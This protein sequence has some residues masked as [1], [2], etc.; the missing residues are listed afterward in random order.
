MA[1]QESLTKKYR[2]DAA[3]QQVRLSWVQLTEQ[4]A[5][6]IRSAGDFLRDD[7]ADD[8]AR[9]LRALLQVSGIRRQGGGGRFEPAD[10]GG[11]P[12]G[13]LLLHP[14]RQDRRRVLRAPAAYRGDPRAAR[15][16]ASLEPGQL[17][18]VR[19]P[20]HP[21]A[22]GAPEGADAAQHDQGV[23]EGLL[24]RW[25]A[26]GGGLHHRRR[27]RPAGAGR[28]PPGAQRHHAHHGRRPDGRRGEGDRQLDP[29]DRPGRRR[30]D[31]VD[32][33]GARCDGGA[34]L[35]RR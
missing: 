31:R 32:G 7:A 15:H 2:T 33:R 27:D 13:V 17:R 4:D 8:R 20:D 21:A 11:R 9:V 19:R 12:G 22:G 28:Q 25:L 10:A 26:R 5:E 34:H 18:H 24:P 1:V 3:D 35:G 14:R 6:L 16:Q 23:P 29:G 30:P